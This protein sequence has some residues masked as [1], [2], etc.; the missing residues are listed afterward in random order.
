MD[1]DI[2]SALHVLSVEIFSSFQNLWPDPDVSIN[3]LGGLASEFKAWIIELIRDNHGPSLKP[4]VF[5]IVVGH[6][7]IIAD[8]VAKASGIR[9]RLLNRPSD[10]FGNGPHGTLSYDGFKIIF[11]NGVTVTVATW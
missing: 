1:A 2:R 9:G 7:G 10:M 3:K 5:A 6:K 4:T 11:P 8:K